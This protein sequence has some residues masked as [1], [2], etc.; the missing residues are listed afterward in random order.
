MISKYKK[1]KKHINYSFNCWIHDSQGINTCYLVE[2]SSSATWSKNMKWTFVPKNGL[3]RKPIKTMVFDFQGIYFTISIYIYISAVERSFVGQFVYQLNSLSG[4]LPIL[5]CCIPCWDITWQP[6]KD[7][8][9][10]VYAAMLG[11]S[12]YI[13]VWSQTNYEAEWSRMSSQPQTPE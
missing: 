12:V 4:H 6:V 9:E 10:A 3:C 5:G 7:I 2:P 8:P 13:S 1:H 11:F